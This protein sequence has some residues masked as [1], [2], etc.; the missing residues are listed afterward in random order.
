M[1]KGKMERN[2]KK[3]IQ[4]GKLKKKKIESFDAL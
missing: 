1:R 3:R 4:G 2:K